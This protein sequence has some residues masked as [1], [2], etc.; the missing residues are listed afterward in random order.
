MHC[1]IESTICRLHEFMQM[2]HWRFISLAFLS[3][4]RQ[5]VFTANSTH[6][7]VFYQFFDVFLLVIGVLFLFMCCFNKRVRENNTLPCCF[8][9]GQFCTTYRCVKQHVRQFGQHVDMLKQ[10]VYNTSRFLVWVNPD[11]DIT[12][13]FSFLVSN[14]DSELLGDLVSLADETTHRESNPSSHHIQSTGRYI[15]V[16][17]MSF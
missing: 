10:H 11:I 16:I 15:K 6:F 12:F 4:T 8:V 1:D 7:A 14:I 17:K 2:L 3:K 13:L 9:E 5:R